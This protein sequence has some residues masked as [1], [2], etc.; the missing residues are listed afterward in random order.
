MPFSRNTSAI[1]A[2]PYARLNSAT[3]PGAM[4]PTGRLALN[5]ALAQHQVI[6]I[7]VRLTV[8]GS[9]RPVTLRTSHRTFW[10]LASSDLVR[11]EKADAQLAAFTTV[12]L[13]DFVAAEAEDRR[14]A[15]ATKAADS[16]RK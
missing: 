15:A 16:S 14:Q 4:P 12:S 10:S 9:R 5:R 3:N 6:P 11:I 13:T 8:R 7:S 1:L 2:I